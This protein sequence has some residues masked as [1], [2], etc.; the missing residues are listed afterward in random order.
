MKIATLLLTLALF[1]AITVTT[2]AIAS[3]K[4]ILYFTSDIK[5]TTPEAAEISKLNAIT[6]AAFDVKVLNGKQTSPK[7][8]VTADYMAG[9]IPPTY[10]DGGVDVGTPLYTVIDPNNPPAPNTLPATQAMVYNGQVVTVGGHSYTFTVAANAITA[11]A[12]Q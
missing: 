11:I 2:V 12:Y 6:P 3:P 9:A 10:R 7:H 8:R 1:V 5:P 4:K